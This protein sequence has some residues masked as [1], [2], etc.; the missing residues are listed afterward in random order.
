M[1]WTGAGVPRGR[2]VPTEPPLLVE[3]TTGARRAACRAHRALL[4]GGTALTP[5]PQQPVTAQ[6]RD[7]AAAAAATAATAAAAAALVAEAEAQRLRELEARAVAALHSHAAHEAAAEGGARATST[8]LGSVSLWVGLSACRSVHLRPCGTR[9]ESRPFQHPPCVSSSQTEACCGAA[10]APPC[11]RALTARR[12]CARPS[13]ATSFTRR[14]RRAALGA[15]ARPRPPR[16]PR[17]QQSRLRTCWPPPCCCARR[18]ASRQQ[19]HA[20]HRRPSSSSRGAS[21]SC[22]RQRG[23]GRPTRARPPAP[24]RSCRPGRSVSSSP[25]AGLEQA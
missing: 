20:P 21:S 18:W 9:I 23:R 25:R 16:R 17:P 4:M 22:S 24:Q 1:S 11:A 8:P 15:R 14:P 5:V 2:L 6:E 3:R 13:P 19:R 10:R 12:S 7:A